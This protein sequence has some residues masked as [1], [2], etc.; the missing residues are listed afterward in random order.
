MTEVTS[1]AVITGNNL[2]A[3]GGIP[4][5]QR[6][7]LLT[8]LMYADHFAGQ[9]NQK[10]RWASWTLHYR[11]QLE[12]AGCQLISRFDQKGATVIHNVREL[13]DLSI[14]VKGLK[15]A[16]N[17]AHLARRSFKAVRLSQYGRLFFTMGSGSG[18]LSRFQVVP[19]ESISEH[20]ISIAVCAL[21]VTT[22]VSPGGLF[23][24]ED[25]REM[26]VRLEG[27]LYHFNL[28]AYAEKR[29]HIEKRMSEIS[30]ASVQQLSI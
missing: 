23:N 26:E 15:D 25:D 22:E 7:D 11:K 20:D 14:E 2:F 3:F 4:Q 19:C 28:Q 5:E 8:M 21:R 6:S 30:Q 12:F 13:D 16:D 17:L 27:G 9:V 10:E 29:Q 18:F 24:L 1:N